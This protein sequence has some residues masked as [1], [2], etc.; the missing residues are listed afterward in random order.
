LYGLV[1]YGV[2]RRTREIGIRIAIGAT[3]L[4]IIA[5][6]L[7]Q[8]MTPAWFGLS[9]GL[10]LSAITARLLPQYVRVNHHFDAQTFYVVLPLVLV[11]TSL[12]AYVPAGRAA[13]LNPTTALRCE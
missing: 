10:I 6:I 8:G 13:R 3:S 2:S 4:R 9:V 1:S 11:V 7:R 12:A 5:M